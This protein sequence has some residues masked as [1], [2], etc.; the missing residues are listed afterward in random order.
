MFQDHHVFL[1][2]SLLCHIDMS[3]LIT[4][5]QKSEKMT[6]FGPITAPTVGLINA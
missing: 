1:D 2:L 6:V 4:M 5:S 3:G